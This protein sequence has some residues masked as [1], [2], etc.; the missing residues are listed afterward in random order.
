MSGSG[1]YNTSLVVCDGVICK[2]EDVK[3]LPNKK[4]VR[5]ATGDE[6]RQYYWNVLQKK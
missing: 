3:N 4:S 6:M 2:W 5:L 1:W